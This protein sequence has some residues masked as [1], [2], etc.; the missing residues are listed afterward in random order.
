[1]SSTRPQTPGRPRARIETLADLIF[2]FALS[3]G[4][5]ALIGSPPTSAGD[6]NTRILEFMFTFFIL[7]TAWIIYTTQ[8]S[9]L[10][11]ETRAVTL[12]NVLML[13]LVAVVPYLL[14]QS[15]VRVD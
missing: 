3:I 2:G 11:L 5:I 15:R 8:M 1:M 13:A 14:F 7:I 9:V 10:P 6:I 12:L 4:A